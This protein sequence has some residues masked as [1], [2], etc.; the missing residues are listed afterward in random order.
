MIFSWLCE[1]DVEAVSA[2]QDERV[3][4]ICGQIATNNEGGYSVK[5]SHLV[6]KIGK[7]IVIQV[8]R[9]DFDFPFAVLKQSENG[10]IVSEHCDMILK[11]LSRQAQKGQAEN[12]CK[13]STRP[14]P[15]P[16]NFCFSPDFVSMQSRAF[17]LFLFS[18]NFFLFITRVMILKRVHLPAIY[19][20]HMALI[21]PELQ[22]L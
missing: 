18:R 20:E 12:V 13:D 21:V 2:C 19:T 1:F 3:D 14:G 11:F 15:L 4:H 7:T 22:Q 17:S 9:L 5:S 10:L 6:C 16:F 8:Y